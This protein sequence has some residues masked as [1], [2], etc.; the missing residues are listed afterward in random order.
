M[1]YKIISITITMHM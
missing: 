1:I